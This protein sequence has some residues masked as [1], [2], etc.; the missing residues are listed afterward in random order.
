MKNM[1]SVRVTAYTDLVYI[2]A[3]VNSA[4]T[5]VYRRQHSFLKKLMACPSFS[6]SYVGWAISKA[7]EARSPMGRA[8]CHLMN[9][10]QPDDSH[11]V[12]AVR[13]SDT[14]RR[15]QYSETN[16]SLGRHPMYSSNSLPEFARIA[17]TRLRTGSHF[18]RVE[19]GR[20]SRLD[21]KDRVC[22]CDN[23]SIQDERHVLL[24]C[25]LTADI[26]DSY[27]EL[28]TYQSLNSLFQ[29]DNVHA[30]AMFCYNVLNKIQNLL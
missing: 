27:P 2:E 26:R 15:K 30:V 16:P 12:A 22:S 28:N 8:I 13:T 25:I 24:T 18:L 20:W 3:G 9:I 19:T 21:L 23:T 10:P 11:L 29:H 5:Y 6:N 7:I 4:T 17:V 14:T 1:L